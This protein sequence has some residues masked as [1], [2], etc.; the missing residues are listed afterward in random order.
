MRWISWYN[1]VNK[2]FKVANF[3]YTGSQI[4]L[5]KMFHKNYSPEK[6]VMEIIKNS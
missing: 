3:K 6:A 5:W 1:K 2:L 4:V